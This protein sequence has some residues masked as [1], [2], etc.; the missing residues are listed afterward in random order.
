MTNEK[1]NDAGEDARKAINV[2]NEGHSPLSESDETTLFLSVF[3]ALNEAEE[4]GEAKGIRKGMLRAAEIA[5]CKAWGTREPNIQVQ[6]AEAIRK[7]AE[8]E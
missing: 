2:W 8:N 1:T 6:I 3:K 5:E 4:R 7:E